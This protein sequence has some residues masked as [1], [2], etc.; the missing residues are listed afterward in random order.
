MFITFEGIEGSGKTTQIHYLKH[1]FETLG[2][3][4]VTT[5]E[6]GGTPMGKLLR[7]MI[8]N[9]QVQ[10]KHPNTEVLLFLADR[11]EHLQTVVKPAL[12]AGSVVL[13]DRYCDST[14]AY[15]VGGRGLSAEW[16]HA[17]DA[18]FVFKP[19]KTILLD[20][21]AEDGIQRAKQRALLDRFEQE[22]LD[23]HRR[24]R[25]AYLDV[26]SR[27]AERFVLVNGNQTPQAV[28]EDILKGLG[29]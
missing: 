8:L 23:F 20:L 11:F 15:Q 26:A 18:G 24:V 29:L 5:K 14:Y 19:N 10:F 3:T 7:E 1:H 6:P 12:E 22:A 25:Q 21:P 9:P 17:I 13:C 28:F 27:E 4:V 2:K 16:I